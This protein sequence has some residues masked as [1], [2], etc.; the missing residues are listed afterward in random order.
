MVLSPFVKD[1]AATI[2]TRKLGEGFVKVRL[3][4]RCYRVTRGHLRE[5]GVRPRVGGFRRPALFS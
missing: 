3:D 1:K 5:G 2:M 4:G